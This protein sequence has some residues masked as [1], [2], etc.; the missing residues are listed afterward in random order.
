MVTKD[1]ENG[2]P[3]MTQ[4]ETV[5]KQEI[6]ARFTVI[7]IGRGLCQLVLLVVWMIEYASV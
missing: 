3:M 5:H 1:K 7:A 2:D 4:L 6:I